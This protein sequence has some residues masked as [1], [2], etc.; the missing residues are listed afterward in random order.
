MNELPP[1]QEHLQL[2][3]AEGQSATGTGPTGEVPPISRQTATNT[4]QRWD[5]QLAEIWR[6]R[7]RRF[8]QHGYVAG[9]AAG[10]A[11]R[12]AIDPL[13]VRIA[14]VLSTLFGG[15][16]V[17]IYLVAWLLLPRNDDETSALGSLFSK[18]TSSVAKWKTVY[19]SRSS[20]SR[21]FPASTGR[22][23]WLI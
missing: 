18:R 6:T 10:F 9:V 2:T 22:R 11:L 7:P 20:S 15:I 21:C 4:R 23:R 19:C 17:S 13:V 1:P 5:D 16:G 14:L 8:P 12:Y 3:S